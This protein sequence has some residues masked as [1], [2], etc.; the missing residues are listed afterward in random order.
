[1]F[2]FIYFVSRASFS[3]VSNLDNTCLNCSPFWTSNFFYTNVVCLLIRTKFLPYIL[4][5]LFYLCCFH[6]FF[7]VFFFRNL[8]NLVM[9]GKK[10]VASSSSNPPPSSGVQ[11]IGHPSNGTYCHSSKGTYCLDTLTVNK[12]FFPNNLLGHDCWFYQ[13]IEIKV[14]HRCSDRTGIQLSK[15]YW[16][17]K[18]CLSIKIFLYLRRYS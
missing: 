13:R 12:I 7:F 1:M 17:H 2:L 6:F 11:P 10:H 8:E 9:I 14:V 15:D 4:P 16:D 3:F 18:K 5:S